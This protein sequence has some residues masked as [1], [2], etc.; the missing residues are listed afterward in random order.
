MSIREVLEHDHAFQPDEVAALSEAFD[1]AL[2]KLRLVNRQD[3]AAITLAKI[4][5][6]LAKR[7]ERD[8][9]RLSDG[10]VAILS[11]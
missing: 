11:K 7:G 9:V 6:E 5:I 2:Q 8:P 10:A 4:I 1:L 3:P